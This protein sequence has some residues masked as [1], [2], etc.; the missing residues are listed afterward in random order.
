MANVE[1]SVRCVSLTVH[2]LREQLWGLIMAG[3]GDVVPTFVRGGHSSVITI[4]VD[5][6]IGE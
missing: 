1:T 4:T 2:Q 6:E 3:Y 5:K